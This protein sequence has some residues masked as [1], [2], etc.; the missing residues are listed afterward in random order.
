MAI[1]ARAVAR[2]LRVSPRKVRLIVDAIRGKGAEEALTLLSFMPQP[3]AK[4]VAKV[5]RS[6][7]SNAVDKASK[8]TPP[9]YLGFDSLR[10]TVAFA[11]EGPTMKRFRPRSRG[12]VSPILKR[13]AHVTV[14]VAD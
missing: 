12:R 6:A 14:V 4:D 2:G 11:D 1:T 5:V 13:S 7:A 8:L 10:I 9:Q 3:S